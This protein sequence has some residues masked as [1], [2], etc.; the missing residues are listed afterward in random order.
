MKHRDSPNMLEPKVFIF[1]IILALG[2]A[3]LP[4]ASFGQD[5]TYEEADAFM[6]KSIALLRKDPA[7]GV[8]FLKEK[9]NVRT[10][11]RITYDFI[12]KEDLRGKVLGL[13]KLQ[14]MLLGEIFRVSGSEDE[15]HLPPFNTSLDLWKATAEELEQANSSRGDLEAEFLEL[16]NSLRAQIA[17]L[18][19]SKK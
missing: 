9:E 11:M 6:D 12:R 14:A 10:S 8:A 15:P 17:D 4:R 18:S 2:G 13:K 5:I 19:E 16:Y 1:F 3:I 7:A